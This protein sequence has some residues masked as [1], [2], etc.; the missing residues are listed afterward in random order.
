MNWDQLKKLAAKN[1]LAQKLPQEYFDRLKF[2]IKEIEKQGTNEY[3]VTNYLAGKKWGTNPSGLV[4]PFL[5]GMTDVD[6][7]KGISKI[8]VESLNGVEDESIIIKLENGQEICV[9]PNTQILTS[10]GYVKASELNSDHTIPLIRILEIKKE[11]RKLKEVGSDVLV[12]N[13]ISLKA[14]LHPIQHKVEY[15][16]DFP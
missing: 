11:R 12:L 3:W 6:P 14:G 8:M 10:D 13:R 7:I 5:L 9:S 4:I 15:Q 2:E 16:T 1:Y